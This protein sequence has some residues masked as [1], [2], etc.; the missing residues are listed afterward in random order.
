MEKFRDKDFGND[1]LFFVLPFRSGM[2]T[3]SLFKRRSKGYETR[4]Q[5]WGQ[6]EIWNDDASLSNTGQFVNYNEDVGLDF[7]KTINKNYE[8]SR[9]SA[10]GIRGYSGESA[11]ISWIMEEN[12]KKHEPNF[13]SKVMEK[14]GLGKIE[15][16]YEVDPELRPKEAG[17]TTDENLESHLQEAENSGGAKY[18]TDTG[19]LLKEM[20][21]DSAGTIEEKHG[22][23]VELFSNGT[24]ESGLN[25]KDEIDS[26]LLSN[27]ARKSDSSATDEKYAADVES[28][29]QEEKEKDRSS[30]TSEREHVINAGVL[31]KEAGES[32]SGTTVK[33]YET[34]PELD[35]KEAGNGS[36]S[37]TDEKHE[38]NLGRSRLKE[39]GKDSSTTEEEL[40]KVVENGSGTTYDLR[41]PTKGAEENVSS[42]IN[43]TYDTNTDPKTKGEK[44]VSTV[45][46]EYEAGVESHLKKLK[47]DDSGTT[48]DP[49]SQTK[50]V[51]K[52]GLN[53]TNEGYELHSE[54]KMKKAD[55]N[56]STIIREEY[57][58]GVESH[59][60][61]LKEDDS[62]TTH[63]PKSQ[64]KEVGK[65]GL[66]TTNEGYE[67][68]SESK[69]KKADK[70]VS[71]II[72]EE[73]EAGVESHLKK[74]KEDD[75]GTTHDPKSQTKEAGKD[76]SNT[77]NEGHELHSESETKEAEKNAS[78]TIRKEHEADVESNLKRT[79]EHDL[80]EA[81]DPKSETKEARKDASAVTEKK[82]DAN[83]ESRLK[84]DSA[85]SGSQ[86]KE[87]EE[88]DSRSGKQN[89]SDGGEYLIKD[90]EHGNKSEDYRDVG[91]SVDVK[92]GEALFGDIS[93]DNATVAVVGGDKP[94][95]AELPVKIPEVHNKP[96]ENKRSSSD[97][98]L[99]ISDPVVLPAV[100]S[101]DP[102]RHYGKNYYEGSIARESSVARPDQSAVDEKL[103]SNGIQDRRLY[104]DLKSAL[105]DRNLI[106]N[107]TQSYRETN[108]LNL[109]ANDKSEAEESVPPSAVKNETDEISVEN[110]TNEEEDSSGLKIARLLDELLDV[111]KEIKRWRS[112]YEENRRTRDPGWNFTNVDGPAT[113]DTRQAARREYD[114]QKSAAETSVLV[115]AKEHRGRVES[116]AR[117]ESLNRNGTGEGDALRGDRYD[118][119]VHSDEENVRIPQ[120]TK[121]PEILKEPDF[122]KINNSK[123]EKDS[124]KSTESNV[125]GGR[126]FED[127]DS[128]KKS[129]VN[130][131]GATEGKIRLEN[132][133]R[134]KD[135]KIKNFQF[136]VNIKNPNEDLRRKSEADESIKVKN[137][138]GKDESEK[139]NEKQH[140]A[141]DT[142]ETTKFKV[143]NSREKGFEWREMANDGDKSVSKDPKGKEFDSERNIEAESSLIGDLKSDKFESSDAKEKKEFESEENSDSERRKTEGGDE[144]KVEGLKETEIWS[145]DPKKEKKYDR[146]TERS[147][148]S[149]E[150]FESQLR[151]D[152][153]STSD[154]SPA[155][156]DESIDDP[157][158][159]DGTTSQQDEEFSEGERNESN[160]HVEKIDGNYSVSERETRKH[161]KYAINGRFEERTAKIKN[162]EIFK[163]DRRN[164]KH[165]ESYVT[166]DGAPFEASAEGIQPDKS[167][168]QEYEATSRERSLNAHGERDTSGNRGKENEKV[169][170]REDA[171]ADEASDGKYKPRADRVE[172]RNERKYE[173]A[174]NK[175]EEIGLEINEASGGKLSSSEGIAEREGSETSSRKNA[176]SSRTLGRNKSSMEENNALIKGGQLRGDGAPSGITFTAE[177]T[178]LARGGI[179]EKSNGASASSARANGTGK[180]SSNDP[181]I[182][183]EN[184]E[185]YLA[186]KLDESSENET[187]AIRASNIESDRRF[188][189][190]NF[191]TSS[192][193]ISETS[194]ESENSGR[195]LP[196]DLN[197]NRATNL[198]SIGA[199]TGS[200]KTDFKDKFSV[201]TDNARV[202]ELQ[203]ENEASRSNETD[204]FRV[205][206]THAENDSA[207]KDQ[208]GSRVNFS[209]LSNTG[210]TLGYSDELEGDNSHSLASQKVSIKENEINKNKVSSMDAQREHESENKT[211]VVKVE[212][213]A[214]NEVDNTLEIPKETA[215]RSVVNSGDS[216]RN[217]YNKSLSKELAKEIESKPHSLSEDNNLAS[218]RDINTKV[219]VNKSNHEGIDSKESGRKYI[220]SDQKGTDTTESNGARAEQKGEFRKSETLTNVKDESD[221]SEV[222]A[223]SEH[224]TETRLN[225]STDVRAELLIENHEGIDP[226]GNRRREG[227]T[228]ANAKNVLDS[229]LVKI[230]NGS[231]E[232]EMSETSN[233]NSNI[234][235]SARLFIE[236]QENIHP[237]GESGG[238]YT[239]RD[240]VDPGERNQNYSKT[241]RESVDSDKSNR[242]HIEEGTVGYRETEA[243]EERRPNVRTDDASIFDSS[244]N[245]STRLSVEN[246]GDTDPRENRAKDTLDSSREKISAI[247]YESE[248]VK[249]DGTLKLN[250]NNELK[251]IE[252]KEGSETGSGKTAANGVNLERASD[253]FSTRDSKFS[254]NTAISGERNISSVAINQASEEESEK[255]GRKVAED[256]SF[257]HS[258][259]KMIGNLS[260]A[261]SEGNETEGSGTTDEKLE[262]D[263][264]RL[265]LLSIARM[266]T[267]KNSE[268][269]RNYY[270]VRDDGDE[271]INR[272]EGEDSTKGLEIEA[273]RRIGI[274]RKQAATT[275]KSGSNG[276]YVDG[277][278][279]EALT[280]RES[281][282]R[283]PNGEKPL[284]KGPDAGIE[285]TVNNG[286]SKESSS[287]LDTSVDK[288]SLSHL[289]VKI[290]GRDDESGK[291]RKGTSGNSDLGDEIARN[292]AKECDEHAA[293]SPPGQL[294]DNNVLEAFPGTSALPALNTKTTS[295]ARSSDTDEGT[296]KP[297]LP[298]ATA[299]RPINWTDNERSKQLP[300]G[301]ASEETPTGGETSRSGAA[302]LSK[303]DPEVESFRA[304][305]D[306]T[307]K[308]ET[309]ERGNAN[310][311]KRLRD[312]EA[313]RASE[314]IPSVFD[315]ISVENEA[316]GHASGATGEAK[317]V[318]NA[319]DTSLSESGVNRQ[320]KVDPSRKNDLLSVRG[321]ANVE[322]T[323][324]TLDR[325]RDTNGEHLE[326][327][328]YDR[329]HHKSETPTIA[330]TAEDEDNLLRNDERVEHG[331]KKLEDPV[332]K[333]LLNRENQTQSSSN[334]PRI[335]G[336]NSGKSDGPLDAGIKI[337]RDKLNKETSEGRPAQESESYEDKLYAAEGT[338]SQSAGDLHGTSKDEEETQIQR[339]LT[340]AEIAVT[341]FPE[342]KQQQR[343]NINMEEHGTHS[344]AEGS[345][346]LNVEDTSASD[347]VSIKSD[348]TPNTIVTSKY[349]DSALND[350]PSGSKKITY[351]S[352][353]E[354]ELR[355]S[356]KK[357]TD[358]KSNA[359]H[360]DVESE[361]K[362]LTL[363]KSEEATYESKREDESSLKGKN[364]FEISTN[365]TS[366]VTK[367]DL[368]S[369]YQGPALIIIDP[370]NVT[371]G[372][373]AQK[374]SRLNS[375][376]DIDPEV[377]IESQHASGTVANDSYGKLKDPV[378]TASNLETVTHESSTR[379]ESKLNLKERI[380]S[381]ASV[382]S[383]ATNTV[384]IDSRNDSKDVTTVPSDSKNDS[385]FSSKEDIGTEVSLGSYYVSNAT[386]DG[387]LTEP[388][389][390]TYE[391][392]LKG[393]SSPDAKTDTDTSIESSI[394]E[395]NLNDKFKDATQTGS[396]EQSI[397]RHSSEAEKNREESVIGNSSEDDETLSV[398]ELDDQH[399]EANASEINVSIDDSTTESS[400]N[401]A[402]ALVDEKEE[403]TKSGK[404]LPRVSPTIPSELDAKFVKKLQS[405]SEEFAK[406]Q[407]EVPN[408]SELSDPVS[409]GNVKSHFGEREPARSARPSSYNSSSKAS[410]IE[411]ANDD[412]CAVLRSIFLFTRFRDD[413]RD[414]QVSS[415]YNASIGE[416]VSSNVANVESNKSYGPASIL[417]VSAF[418]N[419]K[420]G[421]KAKATE[422]LD[423]FTI[424]SRFSISH[425]V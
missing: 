47:E 66:N 88:G 322:S 4:A 5:S 91:V 245:T 155:R 228:F 30:E 16:H 131:R 398:S 291:E 312:D 220:K 292:D 288:I 215:D 149:V 359:M 177:E 217:E 35:L 374:V 320:R 301:A 326:L 227:E 402:G 378:L 43:K 140:D 397:E 289:G 408:K 70:N 179:Y 214:T 271:E 255:E 404:P 145:R 286:K 287:T 17:E 216:E 395:N 391:S 170:A 34:N 406:P 171:S 298:G 157:R 96:S 294:I 299:A 150:R 18:E 328:I 206:D 362:E 323:N 112:S 372:S 49:K 160:E 352:D 349:E 421:N 240:N 166:R 103:I 152:A 15:R 416:P 72:R 268:E 44:N 393:H 415:T 114:K 353:T 93:I 334:E 277:G 40:K 367:N 278:E 108:N 207:D 219:L 167:R 193:E 27:K 239:G 213:E 332:L 258:D 97:K 203:G 37:G 26:K 9:S 53:T 36:A 48:H 10:N 377:S 95:T 63:D 418:G 365:S 201:A 260:L 403:S 143:E 236:N 87:A 338:I 153:L 59:L 183:E 121:D 381:D 85:D 173:E 78:A 68:H 174:G 76:G 77:T 317:F 61:K 273:S 2:F 106:G 73:Y 12:K 136:D 385:R 69:M 180:E 202:M 396:S 232:E 92:S 250:L 182:R 141:S 303:F 38:T 144:F 132:T 1:W 7:E 122:E 164:A 205:T 329:N 74:L 274:A 116:V 222:R 261:S 51:G 340:E 113:T 310:N 135:V 279:R 181:G 161:A 64:I 411:A 117:G 98:S 208:S 316:S 169:T 254:D 118:Y 335:D 252:T 314:S 392:K 60:K 197:G 369:Q 71:T 337:E 269:I 275:E 386:K 99:F 225:S 382:K 344:K 318:N 371:H 420:K 348:N 162:D 263:D 148:Q 20:P 361:S 189:G 272:A 14:D 373:E 324:D 104:Q 129:E 414:N 224:G 19:S 267:A 56:V 413:A 379:G 424:Y 302:R 244:I 156:N 42:T 107:E 319:V 341:K 3:D 147:E 425:H 383:H 211:R 195:I 124:L 137:V 158:V 134:G 242:K 309:V 81:Y 130:G 366:N 100:E 80:N 120:G 342:L 363:N 327:D 384:E 247:S 142:K 128:R 330:H 234:D 210:V 196:G 22:T 345:L 154:D 178:A 339:A 358:L 313:E 409:S 24:E 188:N 297:R 190:T 347:I 249:T 284:E 82:H 412:L 230:K 191:V 325:E 58:A 315:D 343:Q 110:V 407:Q 265:T 50:E 212:K 184:N 306:S 233:F 218:A 423:F 304:S 259:S 13:D 266:L 394:D 354:N 90:D 307:D 187:D 133:E 185:T 285:V 55:K 172:T 221:P 83:V 123:Y 368:Q 380:D 305:E 199:R 350:G 115:D 256:G 75:S 126:Y 262:S 241:D 331:E 65:D 257:K 243:H 125:E 417:Q 333:L 356:L 308:V 360:G 194:R 109:N 165:E 231:D 355:N 264:P 54:S 296:I 300:I 163:E 62:G 186:R 364:D 127:G 270:N 281:I 28:D 246:Q 209:N 388:L 282:T 23:N 198:S 41:S 390:I 21:G 253:L 375:K 192:S 151:G 31:L 399:R 204:T 419:K 119:A 52:D 405:S 387:Q 159:G 94:S 45:G 248:R 370:L 200:L 46:E 111:R 376:T 223:G 79:K 89:R 401:A 84:E 238:K 389:K 175:T 311:A 67:L 295:E 276:L 39:T 32:E 235:P 229:S 102:T 251:S 11:E 410:G 57:E 25:A 105:K 6:D 176:E 146:E 357:D 293:P 226:V 351:D 290:V 400:T 283:H 336:N 138:I 8:S 280:E 346:K 33:I 29:L 422:S 101:Q 86:T 237:A 321:N 168:R 139:N